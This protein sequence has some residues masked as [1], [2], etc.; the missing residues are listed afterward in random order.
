MTT[1]LRPTGPE[2]R[3]EDG[4]RRRSFAI[5]DNGR[6]VGALTLATDSRFAHRAGRL[7]DLTVEPAERRRGRGTVAVLA[8]EE[9]LRGW[10]C[11]QADATVDADDEGALR[12]ATALG[13]QP[14]GHLL[15]KELKEPPAPPPA[16]S[17]ARPM[18]EA[19]F[20]DWLVEE[21]ASYTQSWVARGVPERWAAFRADTDV[22]GAFPEGLGSAGVLLRVLEH[23][24]TPVGT[25]WL[26][27]GRTHEERVERGPMLFG[28][29]VAEEQRGHG[30]G[31]TLLGVAE[32]LAAGSGAG[33]L[34]LHVFAGNVPAS[35][36]YASLGFQPIRLHLSKPL[37]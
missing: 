8:A 37:D 26:D 1:T 7:L 34:T 17:V 6:P 10:G 11:R 12:L 32:D 27:L 2:E 13:Y 31:R 15:T 22:D 19:E 28:V 23:R 16:G 5:A 9:V 29:R 20:Q 33:R 18:A 36:L 30:H 24:G 4:G 25:C 35:R 21:R 3:A 14:R